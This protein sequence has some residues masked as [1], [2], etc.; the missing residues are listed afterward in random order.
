MKR[1]TFVL[2]TCLLLFGIVSGCSNIS[3]AEDKEVLRFAYASNSQP[4]IDAMNEFG[5]LLAE[6]TNGQLDVEYFPDGQLGG[7]RELIELTQTDATDITKVSGSALEGFSNQYSIFGIPYLFDSED[8]YYQVLE[9]SEIM[10]PIY[11]STEDV[12]LTGLTYYD[13]GARNFY[14]TD[15]PVETPDDL[16]GKNIRVMQSETA[17]EMIELLGGSP[18][19]MGSDEVYTSLQQGI[20][21]GAE[22]NEFVLDTAGHGDV[23]KYYSYDEHTRVPDIIVMNKETLDSLTEQQREAVFESAEE[24]TAFQK[25]VWRE[26]VENEKEIAAEEHGVEYNEVD[27]KPFQDAVQPIHEEFQKDEEFSEVYE[28]IRNLAENE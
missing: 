1:N 14:M 20:I 28:A 3:K 12:G 19:P 23:A 25:E 2:L 15:G 9:N 11:Q 10:D 7:E 24:S 17:I 6:K 27:K 4:V 16:Q 22:N 5:R 21:D 13:S 26:A 8:H 18:T